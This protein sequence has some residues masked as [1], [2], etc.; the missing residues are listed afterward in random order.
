MKGVRNLP[1]T[2][3]LL[4]DSSRFSDKS[5]ILIAKRCSLPDEDLW[6]GEIHDAFHLKLQ[7]DYFASVIVRRSPSDA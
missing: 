6:K 1:Q 2:I 7:E 4:K 3:K 5:Q